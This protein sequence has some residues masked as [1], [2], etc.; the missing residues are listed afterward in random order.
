MSKGLISPCLK[1]VSSEWLSELGSCITEQ[2]IQ[3]YHQYGVGW[4]PAL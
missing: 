1:I 4:R 2:L 3:A